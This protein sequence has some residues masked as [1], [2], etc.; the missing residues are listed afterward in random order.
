[1]QD[2]VEQTVLVCAYTN[3]HIQLT[4]TGGKVCCRGAGWLIC[5]A[6]V[7]FVLVVQLWYILWAE[8]PAYEGFH[9]IE[10]WVES[11][12]KGMYACGR[13]GSMNDNHHGHQHRMFQ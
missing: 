8:S 13:Q 11:C 10:V 7:R 2:E 4:Y 3:L 5:S 1:M 12:S 6:G 9:V